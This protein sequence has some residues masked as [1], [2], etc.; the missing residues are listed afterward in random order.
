M[1]FKIL[2]NLVEISEA[3][4]LVQPGDRRTRGSQRLF[5]PYTKVAVYKNSFFPRSIHDWNK[6][7]T[8][9]T[10]ITDIEA[11]KAALH[12]KVAAPPLSHE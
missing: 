6:L 2:H 10:D 3:T 4:Q 5:Q 11:F 9:T 7:P 8:D 1:L 12:S